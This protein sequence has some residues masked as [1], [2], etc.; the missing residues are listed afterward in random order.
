MI[1]TTTLL[2]FFIAFI[3]VTK[4]LYAFSWEQY[5]AAVHEKLFH[6]VLCVNLTI[7]LLINWIPGST[8]S[9]FCLSSTSLRLTDAQQSLST[10]K[11]EKSLLGDRLGVGDI[12]HIQ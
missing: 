7:I 2:T 4:Y 11:N 6:L 8:H 5:Q 3:L 10:T 9:I 12:N 1:L